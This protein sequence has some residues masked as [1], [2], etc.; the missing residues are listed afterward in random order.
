MK[1]CIIF[2]I[3][4]LCTASPLYSRHGAQDRSE[5]YPQGVRR[6]T[7]FLT[8]QWS[9]LTSIVAHRTRLNKITFER[10]EAKWGL[11]TVWGEEAGG[12]GVV[13]RIGM[14]GFYDT[15]IKNV[16]LGKIAGKIPEL[17]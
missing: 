5:H 12:L 7:P 4:C 8:L 1:R 10:C 11:E 3:S 13:I 16:R 15:G 17:F 6:V 14:N 9:Y 2:S